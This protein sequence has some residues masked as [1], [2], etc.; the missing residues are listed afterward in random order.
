MGEQ[1]LEI[2]E[3]VGGQSEMIVR[4]NYVFIW[5]KCRGGTV[6]FKFSLEYSDKQKHLKVK[7]LSDEKAFVLQHPLLSDVSTAPP[8]VRFSL[9]NF[10]F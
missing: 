10:C 6:T 7:K 3:G 8:W 4:S 5:R 2:A 1:A 9:G